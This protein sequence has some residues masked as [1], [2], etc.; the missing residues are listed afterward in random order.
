MLTIKCLA[1]LRGVFRTLSKRSNMELFA[2][3][4]NDFQPLTTFVKGSILVVWQGSE[5]ASD[6]NASKTGQVKWSS[7]NMVNK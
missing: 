6:S 2:K 4:G 7:R 1:V 3:I 5:Q